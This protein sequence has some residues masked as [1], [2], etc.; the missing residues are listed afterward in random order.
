M[1]PPPLAD[2]FGSR[3]EPASLVSKLESLGLPGARLVVTDAGVELHVV[4]LDSG[5]DP[6]S[7]A[8]TWFRAQLWPLT[9]VRAVPGGAASRGTPRARYVDQRERRPEL[10][11]LAECSGPEGSR[12][13][14]GSLLERLG[15]DGARIAPVE[16]VVP[17]R[18][19]DARL[20]EVLA[21]LAAAWSDAL[22]DRGVDPSAASLR[23]VSAPLRA[24]AR[25][26]GSGVR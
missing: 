20:G 19:A 12:H 18:V 21:S 25:V 1:T 17:P 3:R 4:E 2:A 7:V 24:D 15:V 14:V 13:A 26:A 11:A 8:L 22:A 9:P 6:V 16:A 23:W 10:L 5:S